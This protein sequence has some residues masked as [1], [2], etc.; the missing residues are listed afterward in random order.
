MAL[1]A[2]TTADYATAADSLANEIEAALIAL[3]PT[4]ALGDKVQRK[5]LIL[6]IAQ[7]VV[8]HLSKNHGAFTVTIPNS[9]AGKTVGID[10]A[11]T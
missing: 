3:V 8:Q 2:G 4:A 7:G 1:H 10:I 11:V 6:A 5:G 9:P